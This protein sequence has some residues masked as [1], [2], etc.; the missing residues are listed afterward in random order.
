[1]ARVDNGAYGEY[2]GRT[3]SKHESGTCLVDE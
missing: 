3:E 1:M 2:T